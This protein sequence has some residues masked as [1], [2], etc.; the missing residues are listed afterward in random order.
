MKLLQDE[1]NRLKQELL[2]SG[3]PPRGNPV[4]PPETIPQ[5]DRTEEI[6]NEKERLRLEFER[7]VSEIRRQCEAERLTKEDIQ[8]KYDDLKVQYDTELDALNTNQNKED[9]QPTPA[10]NERNKTSKKKGGILKQKRDG[11]NLPDGQETN[12]ETPSANDP[13][14]QKQ[15]LERLM[16]LENKLVGGEE[17]NNEERKKK[18]KKKI[19]E[20]KEKHEQRKRFNNAINAD[21]DD[22]LLKVFDNAQEQVN[23]LIEIDSSLGCI[24][25]SLYNEKIRRRT[26]R[27]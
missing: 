14:D 18:R 19:N 24:L 15:K 7:E 9:I 23:Q 8:R 1:I 2:N 3:N 11:E 17:A 12:G 21:D 10:V 25:A 26:C 6:E 27:K 4:P 22:T 13:V 16:E 5:V 20:M